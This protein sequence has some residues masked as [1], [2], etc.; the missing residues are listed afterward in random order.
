MSE[1]P[2]SIPTESAAGSTTNPI[3]ESI[4]DGKG[5]IFP[6]D[7]CGADMVFHIGKQLMA[8]EYCGY[9]KKIDLGG[10]VSIEE[11]DYHAMLLHIEEIKEKK[12]SEETEKEV[13]EQDS[14]NQENELH[15]ESC[16]ATVVFTGS[17]TSS[18]CPYCA[19]PIQRDDVHKSKDRIPVDGV[20]PF[21]ITKKNA[22]LN[23]A[24]WV[25][26]RWFAPN[27]FLKKGVEGK[28][29]GIYLPYWTYDSMT[30]TDYT[31]QR[32]EYYY[33]TVGTGKNRRQVRRTSWY[34]ASGFFQRF[35]D[36]VTVMSS[37]DLPQKLVIGLEPWPLDQCIPFSQQVL[38]GFLA[39][40]YETSLDQGFTEAKVRIDSAIEQEVRSRIGGD[41]QRVTSIH[42]RYDAIT[43][44]HL[45]LPL[46]LMVYRYN[47]KVYQILINAGT[48]EI[49]GERPYSWVK[50]MFAVLGIATV[51]TVIG[52]FA[53]GS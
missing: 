3:G 45:L 5:R 31:G 4:N 42:S 7:T 40:T 53:A 9:E 36:D 51:G 23:L 48:G 47:D 18:E 10:E 12:E 38:A 49:Q 33:V 34:P 43:F 6:C 50:I 14:E 1:R 2:P 26:S 8:C 35:F 19:S 30:A 15:C 11:Q 16:G 21:K 46:W 39:R 52:L 32:G 37:H 22:K 20:L 29:N 24:Q 25:K 28:F 13:S 44:K 27:D 17:L 41:T